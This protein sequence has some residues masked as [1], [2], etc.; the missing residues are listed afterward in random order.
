MVMSSDTGPGTLAY[1]IAGDVVISLSG[2]AVDAR[3]GGRDRRRLT[4]GVQRLLGLPVP[5]VL[6]LEAERRPLLPRLGREP[7]RLLDPRAE[8][9]GGGA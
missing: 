3:V 5:G 2:R 9:P 1:V 7:L 8:A 6:R 4:P